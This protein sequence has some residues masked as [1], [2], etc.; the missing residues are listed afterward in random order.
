MKTV[1]LIVVGQGIGG[2]VLSFLAEKRGLSTFIIDDNHASSSSMAAAGIINPITGR[3]Y[4]KSWR[5][6]D[7]IPK[8]KD[9]YDDMTDTIGSQVY[10]EISLY[11][12]LYKAEDE[13]TFLARGTDPI[14][15]QFIGNTSTE[16]EY[17]GCVN[18]VLS[19][20]KVNNALRVHLQPTLQRYHDIKKEKNLLLTERFNYSDLTLEN[21]SVNY[22]GIQGRWIVFSEGYKATFNPFFNA[23]IDFQPVKG[24]VLIVTFPRHSFNS[25]LR[26]KLFIAPLNNDRYWIGSGYQ[27][28]YNDHLPSEEG[29]QKLTETFDKFIN[30]PYTV[31]GHLAGVRP[32]VKERR[33][34]LGRHSK[35]RNLFVFNGLGTKGSS[36]APFWADHLLDHILTGSSLDKEVDVF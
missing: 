19:Y 21:D 14:A 4:V 28:E 15:S 32:A 11:R 24:E 17:S 20:G 22:K 30:I 23:R 10:E 26:H 29:L 34:R 16:T 3:K 35:Y 9:V 13:N 27:W 36:L 33:P 2:T 31:V 7:F 6:E 8:A 18:N 12:A 5:A 25:I 1:D